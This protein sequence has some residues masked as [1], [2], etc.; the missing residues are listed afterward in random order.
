[1]LVCVSP[2]DFALEA[3]VARLRLRDDDGAGR[4]A[5][6]GGVVGADH[7]VFRNRQLREGIAR[8]AIAVG[9]AAAGEAR[10]AAAGA[11]TGTDKVLL[12]D[13]IDEEVAGRIELG[14]AA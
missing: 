14:A 10:T 4:I 2:E 11:A 13:A 6:F 7:L 9:A 3:V 8:V 1:M 12:A 5:I